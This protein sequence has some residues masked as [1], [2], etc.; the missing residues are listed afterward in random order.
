MCA[1]VARRQEF[2]RMFFLSTRFS[3]SSSLSKEVSKEKEAF[4]HCERRVDSFTDSNCFPSH[5]TTSLAAS[6]ETGVGHPSSTKCNPCE[7]VVYVYT[8]KK[9]W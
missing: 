3:L 1:G 4:S 9:M 6:D 8:A 2:R 7:T 5:S